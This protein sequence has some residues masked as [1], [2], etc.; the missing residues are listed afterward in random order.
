M[1][2]PLISQV[3]QISERK[4]ARADLLNLTGD[5]PLNTITLKSGKSRIMAVQS[6]LPNIALTVTKKSLP[7][8]FSCLLLQMQL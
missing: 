2:E 1:S 8:I 6:M 7:Q 5:F 4:K 3:E